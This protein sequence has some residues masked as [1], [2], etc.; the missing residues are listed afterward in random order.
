MVGCVISP[1]LLIFRIWLKFD[2]F[3]SVDAT[4]R[5]LLAMEKGRA[6]LVRGASEVEAG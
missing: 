1:S 5:E 6:N 3:E 4:K 2:C